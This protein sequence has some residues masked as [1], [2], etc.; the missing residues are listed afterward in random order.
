MESGDVRVPMHFFARA[1]P[2]F[3]ELQ[4]QERLSDTAHE[5]IHLASRDERLPKPIRAPDKRRFP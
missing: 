4:A 5:G 2:V 3:G 1:P